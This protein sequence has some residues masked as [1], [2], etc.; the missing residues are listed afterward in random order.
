MYPCV[1]HWMPTAMRGTIL[2]PLHQLKDAYPDV[3]ANAVAKY[4]SRPEVLHSR[5]PPLDCR[6]ND[7]LHLTATEPVSLYRALIDAGDI[8]KR[9]NRWYKIPVSKLDKA[10]LIVCTYAREIKNVQEARRYTPFD[11]NKMSE[12]ATLPTETLE[13]YRQSIAAEKRPMLFSRAPHILYKGPIDI[14][15]CEIVDVQKM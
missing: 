4:D 1:Y 6:W 10:L 7:V 13:H 11:E 5:I 14:S 2:Y 9:W 3:Y 8:S 15:D 12:Y